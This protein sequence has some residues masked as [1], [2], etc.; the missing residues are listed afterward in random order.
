MLKFE[1][2]MPTEFVFGKGAENK[3]GELCKK[4]GGS[5]IFIVYGGKSAVESGLLGRVE[6][7]VKA[8]GLECE[9]MGGVVPNPVLSTA[10]AMAKKAIEFKADMILGIGGGSAIDTA[11]FVAHAAA[12]PDVDGWEFW[13][14]RAI[15]KSMPIGCVPTLPAT[16]T[17][18]S[19]SSVISDDSVTP[20]DKRGVTTE[21]QRPVF[22]LMNPELCMTLPKYQIGAGCV[23]I[24]MHNAERFFTSIRGNNLSDEMAIGVFKNIMKYAPIALKTPTDYEAM[25]E[26]MWTG[27]MAHNGITGLGAKADTPRDGDWGCHQL[28]HAISAIYNSTHGATLSAVFGSWSRYVMD[29]DYSRFADFGRRVLGMEGSDD[30]TLA[31]ETVKAIEAFFKSLDMPISLTE[32]LG[33]KP[34]DEEIVAL[35]DNCSFGKSRTIGIYKVLDV[36]DIEKIYRMA[37]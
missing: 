19:N 33:H 34:S 4:Y 31:E 32:L 9:A 22:A 13:K 11:K 36:S 10:R 20:H 3:A 23:D 28:G 1:F 24:F 29:A 26:V 27:T 21:L 25:S 2:K 16:G 7:S 17:E 37:I 14:G 8:A 35:A 15:P 6:E 18:G 5:R 12:N 30:K